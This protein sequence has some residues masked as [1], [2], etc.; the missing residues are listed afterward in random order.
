MGIILRG[1][2]KNIDDWLV[3]L[4]VVIKVGHEV[5][6]GRLNPLELL[7]RIFLRHAVVAVLAPLVGVVLDGKTAILGLDRLGISINRNA[8]DFGLLLILLMATL[9]LTLFPGIVEATSNEET[10]EEVLLVALIF[11]ILILVV[12]LS[13]EAA[14]A[15]HPTTKH[16]HK[17]RSR[18][19][20]HPATSH[21]AAKHRHEHKL[22]THTGTHA[23]L[24][25]VAES[26]V[27]I[28]VLITLFVTAAM[29]VPIIRVVIRS[30]LPALSLLP[31]EL[32]HFLLLPFLFS[33]TATALLL[34][35]RTKFGTATAR[36]GLPGPLFLFA[37]LLK[38]LLL[39]AS[40]CKGRQSFVQSQGLHNLDH[41]GL[42]NEKVLQIETDSTVRQ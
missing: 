41:I 10:G 11:I 36:L 12:L 39:V 35:P 17:D 6:I 4:L 34:L 30:G 25:A 14:H 29:M 19:A 20:A 33:L 22:L 16:G 21:A 38:A 31:Q 9:G 8:Q 5:I 32:P 28:L 37:L 2:R 15:G 7:L 3:C 24:G 40:S 42:A 23:T 26:L 1:K 13:V 18:D 27:V